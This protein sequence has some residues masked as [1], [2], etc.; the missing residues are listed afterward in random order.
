MNSIVSVLFFYILKSK[1][2]VGLHF[3]HICVGQGYDCAPPHGP[4]LPLT[5]YTAWRGPVLGKEVARVT[6]SEKLLVIYRSLIPLQG[7]LLC[8]LQEERDSG[9]SWALRP[10][11]CHSPLASSKAC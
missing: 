9:G 3:A 1:S 6:R 11:P 4:L 2:V 5:A 8:Q 7:I 10:F